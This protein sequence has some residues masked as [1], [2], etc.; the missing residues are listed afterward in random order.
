MPKIIKSSFSN[1]KPKSETLHSPTKRCLTVI[2]SHEDSDNSKSKSSSKV[3]FWGPP[4]L[5]SGI[6]NI[7][8]AID[9]NDSF[10]SLIIS[11]N[12]CNIKNMVQLSNLDLE[13]VSKLFSRKDLRDSVFQDTIIKVLCL[14][15]C[16]HHLIKE[17]SGLDENEDIPDHFIPD[18][19]K[20]ETDLL[21]KESMSIIK[22]HYIAC[23]WQLHKT[24]LDYLEDSLSQ[25]S[26]IGSTISTRSKKNIS[27][28]S[29]ISSPSALSQDT[30]TS[31]V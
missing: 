11:M 27:F 19:F 22:H 10:R 9:L 5:S 25:D 4:D 20:Q 30:K 21:D 1:E 15:K 6:E 16:F 7:L 31:K 29:S 12:L 13:D 14:G 3:S 24:F 2:K 28:A 8:I 18:T 17:K 26:L 23:Y